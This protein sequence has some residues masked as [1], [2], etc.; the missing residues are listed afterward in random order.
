MPSYGQGDGPIWLSEVNC[1]GHELKLTDCQF[2]GGWDSN[3]CTHEDDVAIKC[4]P[5]SRDGGKILLG[6]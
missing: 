6:F 2:P 5:N 4:L 1:T 3:D